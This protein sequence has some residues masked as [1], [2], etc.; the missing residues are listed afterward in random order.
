MS[1]PD[2]SLAVI[3]VIA[4][5]LAG[6]HAFETLASLHLASHA[7]RKETMPVMYE[8]VLMDNVVNLP[9]YKDGTQINP[10]GFRYTK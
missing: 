5:C 9:Y 10:T 1:P 8:T 6:N 4:E 3:T 2:L 7:V